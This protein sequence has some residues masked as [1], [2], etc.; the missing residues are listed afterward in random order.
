V[1]YR[2]EFPPGTELVSANSR[3]HYFAKAKIMA[4]LRREA[5]VLARDIPHLDRVHVTGIFYPPDRRRR[6]A[7]NILFWAVKAGVDGIVDAG[8]LDDD[9]DDYVLSTTF[10]RGDRKVAKGQVAIELKAAS[11]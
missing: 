1:D 10:I 6:D 5:A 4:A 8:V 11:D 3:M 2:I 7:G 9:N